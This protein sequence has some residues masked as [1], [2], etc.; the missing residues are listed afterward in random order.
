MS[1]MHEP[2]YK[3]PGDKPL[4][5]IMLKAVPVYCIIS[6]DV[7]S[8]P[9]HGLVHYSPF[10]FYAIACTLSAKDCVQCECMPMRTITCSPVYTYQTSLN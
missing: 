3:Y 7:N 1:I 9:E 2:K 6:S 5:T 8:G 10:Q 4:V